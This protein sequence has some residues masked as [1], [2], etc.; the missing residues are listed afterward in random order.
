[1]NQRGRGFAI[2]IFVFELGGLAVGIFLEF[3][4]LKL[5]G[6]FFD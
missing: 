1:V 6:I 2:L 3:F 4:L 5:L